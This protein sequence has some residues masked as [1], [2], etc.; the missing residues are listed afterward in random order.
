MCAW[1]LLEELMDSNNTGNSGKNDKTAKIIQA[2]STSILS[3]LRKSK[4]LVT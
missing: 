3:V 4:R 2:D 1:L